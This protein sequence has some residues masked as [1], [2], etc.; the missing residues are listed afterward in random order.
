MEADAAVWW[1][2]GHPIPSLMPVAGRSVLRGIR[3]L[4]VLATVTLAGGGAARAADEGGEPESSQAVPAWRV[5]AT[6]NYWSGSYG[7]DART[8]LV[9]VP[10]SVRR[11]FRDGDLT[12]TIPYVSVTGNGS[13]RLVGGLPFRTTAGGGNSGGVTTG[14]P[15]SGKRPGA[16]PLATT[17]TDSGLGDII[18]RGRYFVIEEGVV[19]PLVALIGRIKVPTADADRGLGTGEFDEGVGVEL[20]KSLGDRWLLFLDA[21]Y[22]FIGDAPGVDFN[23]QWWYDAGVA[24][25]VTTRL[26]LSMFYEEYRAVV[27]GLDNARDLLGTASYTV[28]SRM[29][30]TGSL[31]VGLSNGA[32]DYGVSAGIYVRF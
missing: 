14:G 2:D 26:N 5:G 12:L 7:T 28:D 16:A 24:Y 20:T 10:V 23:N 27:P 9:Y 22:N 17:S 8:S 29:R 11:Y 15:G 6:V 32:P 21:G 30:L 19:V 18:L 4:L 13:V 3:I 1:R 31:L 25:D